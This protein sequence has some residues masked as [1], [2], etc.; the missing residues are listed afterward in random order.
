MSASPSSVV[1]GGFL[2]TCP[3][4]IT[5]GYGSAAATVTLYAP[6]GR[7]GG[8]KKKVRKIV[9]DGVEREITIASWPIPW[10]TALRDWERP[11]VKE[12][13]I[14]E[15]SVPAPD[16]PGLALKHD[17]RP[18]S[19]VDALSRPSKLKA[20]GRLTAI[21]QIAM[22]AARSE[23]ERQRMLR[24]DEDEILLLLGILE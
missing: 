12:P 8:R 4:L 15:P 24:M 18:Q 7:P 16:S 10:S 19:L 23:F 20:A 21:R 2:F 11:P 14:N 1:T 22:E 9:M 3:L 13:V 6:A 17:F 5:S